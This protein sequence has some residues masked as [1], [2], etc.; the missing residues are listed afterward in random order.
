MKMTKDIQGAIKE[1]KFARANTIAFIKH[2]GDE[3]LRINLPRPALDTFCKH[4]EELIEVQNASI[5]AITTGTM[6]FDNCKSD[7]DYEGLSTVNE[8][9]QKMTEVDEKM[10]EILSKTDADSEVDW[11]G[12]PKTI[13]NQISFQVSHETLHLGQ[14]IAFCYVLDIK[15]PKEVIEAWALSGTEK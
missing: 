6:T 5:E 10:L 13:V 4:F 7:F 8:L 9:L 2:L 15:M 12:E 3:R 11:W 14:L 1:W